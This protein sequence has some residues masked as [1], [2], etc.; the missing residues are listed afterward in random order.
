[1]LLVRDEKPQKVIPDVQ[2]KQDRTLF[3]RSNDYDK[4]LVFARRCCCSVPVSLFSLH[5]KLPTHITH[6]NIILPMSKLKR[7]VKL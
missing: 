7:T 6:S 2:D 5:K 1:M 3:K 4:N